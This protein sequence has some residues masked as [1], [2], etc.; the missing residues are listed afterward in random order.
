MH[1]K[2]DIVQEPEL[3][4]PQRPGDP[5]DPEQLPLQQSTSFSQSSPENPQNVTAEHLLPAHS[6]EQH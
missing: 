1:A 3:G 6:P 4:V 2:P 5:G